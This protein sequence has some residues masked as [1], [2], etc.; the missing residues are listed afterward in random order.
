MFAL[1]DIKWFYVNVYWF[2]ALAEMHEPVYFIDNK[3]GEVMKKCLVIRCW[4]RVNTISIFLLIGLI[5]FSGAGI[6]AE[7]EREK[8]DPANNGTWSGK[9]GMDNFIGTCSPCH[10]ESGKGD[11]PLADGLGE[12]IKPRNLTDAKLLSTKT[13]DELFKVVKFGGASMGFSDSM[14]SQKDTFTDIEI[15]QIIK[16]VRSNI[17]KCKYEGKK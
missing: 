5:A 4:R 12:G 1:F 14:P 9:G 10:G 16:H 2:G 17:C 7:G 6:S 13:D 8:A 3:S 15:K 11:G